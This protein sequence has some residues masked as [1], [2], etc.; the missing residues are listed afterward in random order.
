[1]VRTIVAA[2]LTVAAALSSAPAAALGASAAAQALGHHV[3]PG[4]TVRLRFAWPVGTIAR[5]EATRYRERNAERVDTT[6]SRVRYRMNVREDDDGLLI[7]YDDFGFD[8]AAAG[9][10]QISGL[11]ERIAAMVP[12]IVVSREGE[13]LRIEDVESIR[14]LVDTMLAAELGAEELDMARDVMAS[15]M[16]DEA[17]AAMAAQDWNASVGMWVD[18]DIEL[19]AVYEFEDEA[20][21][22][23]VPGAVI[24][25]IT[26]FWIERWT[27]CTEDGGDGQC[28]EIRVVSRPEPDAVKR[29][30]GEFMERFTG[31]AGDAF[32]FED[33]NVESE[34]LLVTEPGTLLPH[35]VEIAKYVSGTFRVGDETG[36]FSQT[37]VRTLRY[38]YPDPEQ[39]R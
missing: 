18:T 15:M 26:Q 5:V 39:E 30:I 16:S 20:P 19:D 38:T 37:D 17:L 12:R 24:P 31:D 1:M 11:D 23:I 32:S 10:M 34:V 33:F 25:M 27:P 35:R 14:A 6:E 8:E 28:V 29:A 22:P 3:V 21:M 13:F 4:D 7:T 36:E 2:L 9:G